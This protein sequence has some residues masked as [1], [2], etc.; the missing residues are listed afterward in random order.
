[1]QK[2]EIKLLYVEDNHLDV[3][4]MRHL[5]NSILEVPLQF[6]HCVSLEQALDLLKT[7]LFDIILL[8]LAL[9]ESNGLNTLSTV[10]MADS[11]LP[12]IVITGHD[13]QT[14]G[15]QLVKMGAQ[16]YIQKKDL[17]VSR[18]RC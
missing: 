18:F 5:I 12:I 2:D 9:P 15:I 10:Q 8:D 17:L 16:D 4:L 6:N 1:M 7:Q 14:I 11:A 13:D 3:E